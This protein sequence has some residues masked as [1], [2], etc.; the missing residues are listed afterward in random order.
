[1]MTTDAGTPVRSA[2]ALLD[3][4]LTEYYDTEWGIPV[5]DEQ[6][7]FERLTLEAFQTGLSWLVILRRREGFRAA[8]DGFDFERIAGYDER[9][10]AR[11]LAD[12]RIIRNRRKIEATISNARA[13]IALHERGGTLSGL[14]WSHM[15][16]R[17]PAPRT[18]REVPSSSP[19][20][21]ALAK[22]LKRC[23]FLFVGPITVYALMGAIG[24][25]DLHLVDSHRRGCSG[26]W[27]ADGSRAP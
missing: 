14:V 13:L 17:S 26:L 23:G 6:G 16:E 20:S 27:N 10:V 24:A 25:V 21:A 8:F 15:P 5:R 3:P 1:M 9:D 12:E 4:L 2:W 18:V 22:E 7:L 11:L 19:E